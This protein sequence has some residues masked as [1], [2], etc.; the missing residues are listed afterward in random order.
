MFDTEPFLNIRTL[1]DVLREYDWPEP[2]KLADEMPDG[3]V[4]AFDKSNFLFTENPDGEIIVKFLP[5]DLGADEN[6]HLGHALSVIVPECERASGVATPG[7]IQSDIPFASEEKTV[8]GIRN[9]CR[10]ILTHMKGVIA[11]DFSWVVKYLQR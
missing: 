4:M 9:A 2:F 7:L 5:A 3:I 10:I 11:G 8:I 6:L 1:S